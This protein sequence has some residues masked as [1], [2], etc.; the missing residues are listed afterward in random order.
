MAGDAKTSSQQAS[1]PR[2]A[3]SKASPSRVRR[4]CPFRA[5]RNRNRR[6][7]LPDC[8]G[9]HRPL[10]PFG[11]LN[12]RA[13]HAK[14]RLCCVQETFAPAPRPRRETPNRCSRANARPAAP[15]ATGRQAGGPGSPPAGAMSPSRR[16]QRTS[17]WRR[18]MPGGGAGRI[19]QDGVEGPAI[20]PGG[21]PARVGRHA[22]WAAKPEPRQVWWIRSQRAGSTSS[23]VTS[24][25]ASS[26]RCAV[27]PPGAA[28]AS[29]MR[30]GSA[31]TP[32]ISPCSNSGAAS[33]AA[34]SCTDTTP[35]VESGDVVHGPRPREHHAMRCRPRTAAI[36]AACQR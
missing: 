27:F 30:S 23:A 4:R 7:H 29:R 34:A 5:T 16:N 1:K 31:P 3:R 35:F 22:R 11:A 2:Q 9:R 21:R 15:A 6:D 25:S 8:P 17:G 28:Q 18:T 24:A 13:R 14:R 19:Q 12:G 20:P 36:C 26:S 32:A 33:C 10:P